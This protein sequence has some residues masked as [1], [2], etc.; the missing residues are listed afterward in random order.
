MNLTQTLLWVEGFWDRLIK[1]EQWPHSSPHFLK[2]IFNNASAINWSLL[3]LSQNKT[4]SSYNGGL[5]LIMFFSIILYSVT[6][7]TGNIKHMMKWLYR[8]LLNQIHPAICWSTPESYCVSIFHCDLTL[9]TRSWHRWMALHMS[10]CPW[11]SNDC[12]SSCS[13]V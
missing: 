2:T 10:S 13:N 12:W 9:R 5:G 7:C 1:S 3:G 11:A 6:V 4:I 8:S